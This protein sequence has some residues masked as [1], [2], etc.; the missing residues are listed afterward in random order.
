MVTQEREEAECEIMWSAW[1][2][3]GIKT[4]HLALLCP[5]DPVNS[6]SVAFMGQRCVGPVLRHNT[7]VCMWHPELDTA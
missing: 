4:P 6:F 1:C 3:H 5:E 2:V 7:Q